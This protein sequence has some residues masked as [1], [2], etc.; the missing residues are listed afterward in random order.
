M[1]VIHGVYHF[2]PKRVGF[3]NDYCLGCAKPRRSI[4]T[5]TFDVGHIFWIPLIPV[6]YWKHWKCTECGRDPHVHVRT[7]RSFKWLGLAVLLL[8]SGIFWF[9]AEDPV[10][11]PTWFLRIAPL[12]GAV[13]LLVQ[14]LRTPAEPSLKQRLAEIASAA[15]T[16][17]PFCQTPLTVGS[18]ARWTCAGCGVERY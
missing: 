14:L 3:R 9:G 11:A 4:A 13:F 12:V 1:F 18:G 6:G 7:R 16:L 15:D 2:W 5:R 10:Q 8:L 17:C